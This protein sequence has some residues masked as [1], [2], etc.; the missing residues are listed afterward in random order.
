MA[1]SKDW[2]NELEMAWSLMEKLV[3]KEVKQ[4]QNFALAIF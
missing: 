4:G 1:Q 3:S 2:G